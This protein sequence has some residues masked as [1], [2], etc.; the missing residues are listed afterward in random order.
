MDDKE[1][2]SPMVRDTL[3]TL[4]LAASK[5]RGQNF[6]KDENQIRRIVE[7]ILAGAGPTPS[8]LEIGPGLG[9]LTRMLLES[10]A[11]LTAVELDRGLA[12]NLEPLVQIYGGRFQIIHHDILTFDP[13]TLKA[14]NPLFL[15]GN[16]PYNVSSPILFW[17]LKH[18]RNFSGARF[19]LQKEMAMRLTAEPGT[20]DYG[21][22]AVALSLWFKVS[23]ELEVPPSAFHP[24]PKV[25]SAVVALTPRPPEDIP[26]IDPDR[27]GVFTAVV[28]AAR[29]KTILNNMSK[30]YGREKSL[31]ALS[32]LNIDPG[33]R[34]EV[35]PP[36][37]LADLAMLILTEAGQ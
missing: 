7:S 13:E 20:K 5:S 24:R 30:I 29:R 36:R 22:L 26:S 18:R 37:L 28:F 21:R 19:M 6:L 32:G 8:L 27:L 3:K 10:G 31:A 4:G 15:C 11:T 2:K 33:L 34:A 17:L 16:L 35:L 9:A 1:F 23:K 25:D 12:E 14:A